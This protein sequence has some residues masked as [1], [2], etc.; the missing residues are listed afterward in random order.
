MKK[1]DDGITFKDADIDFLLKIEIVKLYTEALNNNI[2]SE[3]RKCFE[4]LKG[5]FYFLGH[6]DFENKQMLQELTEVLT[7]Y[8][9][10][11]NVT[12][13]GNRKDIVVQQG[14][15]NQELKTLLD[16]YMSEIP[17]AYA[18]L[19]LWLKTYIDHADIDKKL[20]EENFNSDYTGLTI[21]KKALEKE[22]SKRLVRLMQPKSVHQ[23]FASREIEDAIPE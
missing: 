6:Y 10:G 1:D 18:Q 2:N 16:R 3:F 15:Q 4:G 14:K 17:K 9:E 22:N 13:R 20:S 19:G 11:L 12:N 21:K 7:D 5:V 23:I 8:F